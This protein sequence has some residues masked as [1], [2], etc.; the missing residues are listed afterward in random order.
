MH[1]S[2]SVARQYNEHFLKHPLMLGICNA[3][4]QARTSH[5][6]KI[7]AIHEG[8]SVPPSDPV[9][10]AA[11]H[12]E[13]E[14]FVFAHIVSSWGVIKLPQSY[15]GFQVLDVETHLRCR[16]T[17][18]YLIASSFKG[19]LRFTVQYDSR[20]YEDE[21]VRGVLEGVREA[22]VHYLGSGDEVKSVGW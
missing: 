8:K 11:R 4:G 14:P 19:S 9:T 10:G 2:K 13:A 17:E 3:F 16:P 15:E 1:R 21:L 7:V 12:P 20:V 22:A 6:E 5:A 18:F